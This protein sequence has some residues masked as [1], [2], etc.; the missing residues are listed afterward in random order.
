VIIGRLIPAGTGYNAYEDAS[1][2]TLDADYS[3]AAAGIYAYG[4]RSDVDLD[5]N[6]PLVL[7]DRTARAYGLEERAGFGAEKTVLPSPI[8]DDDEEDEAILIDADD[9]LDDDSEE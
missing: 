5:Q 6:D 7:D 8:L 2:N 4:D 1:A 3:S 9:F